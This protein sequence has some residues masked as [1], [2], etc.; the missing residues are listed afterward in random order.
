MNSRARHYDDLMDKI[1]HYDEKN[2]Q[3]LLQRQKNII[4]QTTRRDMI[5]NNRE[6]WQQDN[7]E[8]KK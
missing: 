8:K 3:L 7:Y 2:R 6:K 1:N 5:R 4:E